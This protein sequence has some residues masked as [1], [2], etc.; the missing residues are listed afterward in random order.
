MLAQH[1]SPPDGGT[2]SARNAIR[3]AGSGAS[4]ES[5]C[6]SADRA[7]GL[8]I[9]RRSEVETTDDGADDRRHRLYVED[10]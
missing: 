8:L 5:M 1:V 6:R 9:E 4:D 7:H 10:R 3:L 2:S